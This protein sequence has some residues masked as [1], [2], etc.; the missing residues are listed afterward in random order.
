MISLNKFTRHDRKAQLIS[1][2]NNLEFI[3]NT[4]LYIFLISLEIN[5]IYI[6]FGH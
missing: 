2:E 1:I 6:S 3:V 5:I 4:Q